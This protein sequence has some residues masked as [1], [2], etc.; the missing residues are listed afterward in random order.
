M[1]A[2]LVTMGFDTARKHVLPFS[3][4]ILIAF[5]VFFWKFAHL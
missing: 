2:N 1:I 3:A 4:K 5:Y